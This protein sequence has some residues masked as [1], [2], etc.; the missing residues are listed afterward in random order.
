MFVSTASDS[1]RKRWKYVHHAAAEEGHEEH[2]GPAGDDVEHVEEVAKRDGE[3]VLGEGTLE[4]VEVSV[5]VCPALLV[6]LVVQV[7][8]G[9]IGGGGHVHALA[10]DLDRCGRGYHVDSPDSSAACRPAV[11]ENGL[12]VAVDDCQVR[13]FGEQGEPGGGG[14]EGLLNLLAVA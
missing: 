10:V 13:G 12:V 5:M 7:D 11:A 4:G 6:T 2:H 8:V 9:L 14:V 1:K 3:T